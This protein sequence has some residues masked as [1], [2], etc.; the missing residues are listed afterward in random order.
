MESLPDEPA[1]DVASAV[2][3]VPPASPV[4]DESCAL[5]AQQDGIEVCSP[6]ESKAGMPGSKRSALE[7]VVYVGVE[8]ILRGA[9]SDPKYRFSF[10]LIIISKLAG[11]SRNLLGRGP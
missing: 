7:Q 2:A 9:K 10:L 6:R 5:W 3:S 11:H 1:D 8:K 4:F